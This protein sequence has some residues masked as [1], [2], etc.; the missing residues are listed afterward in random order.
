MTFSWVW[1][2]ICDFAANVGETG[3]I[4]CGEPIPAGRLMPRFQSETP[5]SGADVRRYFRAFG[6]RGRS[7]RWQRTG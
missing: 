2:V 6:S 7:E 3:R 4:R 1:G 5:N